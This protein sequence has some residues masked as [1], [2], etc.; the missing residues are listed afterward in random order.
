MKLIYYH[1]DSL[2]INIFIKI[3]SLLT[4]LGNCSIVQTMAIYRKKV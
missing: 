4:I 2:T 3:E 1:T